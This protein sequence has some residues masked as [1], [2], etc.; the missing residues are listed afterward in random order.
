MSVET[1]IA[2]IEATLNEIKRRFSNLVLPG[3]VAAV[4]YEKARAKVNA[5][6]AKTPW[7]PWLTQRAG[8]DVTWWAP[9]IGEQV[10]VLCIDGEP[11][12]GFVL[13]GA[14]YS[15]QHPANA[16]NGDVA[17][18]IFGD[19]AV[20]EYDRKNHS[21]LIDTP[22]EVAVRAGGN[23]E[24]EAGGDVNVTAEGDANVDA[25]AIHLNEGAPVVT[26]AHTCHFTGGPHGH[27]SSSVTAG[28]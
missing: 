12:N 11:A 8:Q 13:P 26:T 14:L 25:T 27:G 15:N 21:Y 4:D 7:L 22:G 24:V 18:F 28:A 6:G 10:V 9:D 16:N 3:V 17:R 20:I 1:R 19:G 23:A 5:A 2:N